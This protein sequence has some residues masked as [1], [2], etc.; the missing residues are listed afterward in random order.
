MKI[1]KMKA[2]QLT[3]TEPCHQNWNQMLPED[4]GKFCL[5]CQKTVVDFTTMSNREVL[6]YFNTNTGNTC[7]RFNDDQLNKTLS[8]PKERSM[9]KWK[10][11]WQFLL[12]AVF[13]M[14]KAEAQT[15]KTMGKP[16]IC[17]PQPTQKGISIKL[18]MVART[19]ADEQEII[20]TINGIIVDVNGIPIPYV[21]VVVTGTKTGVMADS[22]G[23]F[24]INLK[25]N[26]SISISAIGYETKNIATGDLIHLKRFKIAVKNGGVVLSGMEISLRSA[27]MGLTGEIVVVRYDRFTNLLSGKVGGVS[28]VKRTPKKPFFNFLKRPIANEEQFVKLKI[29][30]NPI[31]PG[32]NFQ[33]QLN[34][35]KIDDYRFEIIDASGK[36]IQSKTIK[37]L[38]LQQTETVDGQRLQQSGIYAVHLTNGE[39][40]N[41]FTGKLVVQ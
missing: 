18:G 24:S 34:V 1:T 23:N 3:I 40:K 12:P 19:N 21:S 20:T 5:S 17:Q 37:M 14:H 10:Y 41:V 38:N 28:V 6:N 32:Q 29:F 7:G 22:A 31:T 27:T 25:L 9:G 39:K 36:P 4:Q 15:Q 11:F 26:Q 2:V 8:I 35:P 30:P 16:A 33:V 13:A